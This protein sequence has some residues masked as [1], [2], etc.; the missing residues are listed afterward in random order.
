M[1]DNHPHTAS[2]QNTI[3]WQEMYTRLYKRT[4]Q[5]EA[6]LK[7]ML[8]S[9]VWYRYENGEDHCLLCDTYTQRSKPMNHTVDCLVDAGYQHLAEWKPEGGE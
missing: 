1:K 5:A 2:P 3:T 6:L 4:E 9:G 8:D 7:A